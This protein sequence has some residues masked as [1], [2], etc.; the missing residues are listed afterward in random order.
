VLCKLKEHGYDRCSLFLRPPGNYEA[1]RRRQFERQCG[2][3][4]VPTRHRGFRKFFHSSLRAYWAFC[5]GLCVVE[6]AD[7]DPS[8]T[9]EQGLATGLTVL[10]N[11]KRD[12]SPEGTSC[13]LVKRNVRIQSLDAII[14][15]HFLTVVHLMTDDA[16]Q[17]L[18]ES[19]PSH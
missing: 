2:W 6:H 18:S 13:G 1:K 7:I 10:V 16:L 19:P 11:G 12:S 8:R 17:R 4:F 3:I 14:E 15:K 5:D 9:P